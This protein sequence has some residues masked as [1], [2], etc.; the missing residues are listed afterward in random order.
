MLIERRAILIGL[1]AIG[2]TSCVKDTGGRRNET[3]PGLR[4]L[5]ADFQGERRTWYVF[6]PAG[7]KGRVPLVM[8]LH[9]HGGE[10]AVM[11]KRNE[12]A[13]TLHEKGWIGVFPDTGVE[14]LG[15]Q[16]FLQHIL[17]RTIAEEKVDATRV[18]VVGF[19]GGGKKTYQLAAQRSDIIAS[20]AI[21][22]TRI[23]HREYEE[24]WSPTQNKA[25]DISLLH[26][27]GSKDTVVPPDA[28]RDAAH[29][30]YEPV[31][32]RAGL[33]IWAEHLGAQEVK[34][35]V[36]PRGLP[37][38]VKVHRWETNDGHALVALIDPQLQHRWA[39]DYANRVIVDFFEST[40]P[41]TTGK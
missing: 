20:V 30:D 5:E 32:M 8:A 18:H 40:P 41:N 9:G 38:R 35:P 22:S 17:E 39:G 14:I 26:L 23:G 28:V 24:L 36:R 37:E 33:E 31:P 11:Y 15:D 6:V 1:A 16:V 29:P 4:R 12:W 2:L 27:H 19:S 10:A 3:P 21:A 7:V 25:G 34:Q 13:R